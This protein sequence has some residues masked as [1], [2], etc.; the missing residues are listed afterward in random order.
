MYGSPGEHLFVAKNGW[1][2]AYR[3]TVRFY[4]GTKW[5]SPIPDNVAYPIRAVSET[6]DG[7]I[8]ISSSS[9]IHYNSQT[10]RLETVIQP[11]PVPT[12]TT[13]LSRDEGRRS[14]RWIFGPVFE[15]ADGALWFNKPLSGIVRWKRDSNLMSAWGA[16]D[17]FDGFEPVPTKFIQATDGSIWV[18]T[19]TGVY[20]FHDGVWQSWRLPNEGPKSRD[21]DDFSV[22]DMMEDS[23]GKIWVVFQRAGVMFWDSV[24]WNIVGPFEYPNGNRPQS[25][26]QSSSGAIWIGFMDRDTV[27]YT[28]GR[29]WRYPT[30][31]GTF[32]AACRRGNLSPC[33]WVF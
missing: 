6:S 26:F 33:L 24:R 13:E 15:A 3:D 7:L 12:S 10:D 30:N 25:V 19:L 16:D 28:Q 2:W 29:L 11:E 8:W 4:D 27:K 32:L 1:I 21:M 31:I 9:L 17:G 23:E 14:N 20:R 22:L 5:H 18:G